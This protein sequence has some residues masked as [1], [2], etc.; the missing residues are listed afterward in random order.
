MTVDTASFKAT[1]ASTAREPLANKFH[2]LPSHSCSHAD[3]HSKL[4]HY[5][6]SSTTAL[7]GGLAAALFLCNLARAAFMEPREPLFGLRTNTVFWILGT[8][9]TALA[10]ACVYMRQSRLKLGLV[11]WFA[12]TVVIYWLGLRWQGVDSLR[13][14][15]A[16]LAHT[17][18]I[19]GGLTITLLTLLFSYLLVGSVALLVWDCLAGP[20]ELELKATCVHCGGHIAFS[21]DNLGQK[22][23]C[24]HCSK[25][26]TLRKPS[27]VKTS[28]YF[29]QGHIEFPTHAIGQRIHCPHCKMGIIL[30]EPA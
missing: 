24:P 14:Y 3:V 4:I 12:A 18:T 19:P 11:L 15:I 29:C 22:I 27:M 6:I 13:G 5:F 9:A 17:F 23:P 28:C 26:T 16:G 2:S 7:L 1:P 8:E 20:E 25:E 30:K 10:L 21:S